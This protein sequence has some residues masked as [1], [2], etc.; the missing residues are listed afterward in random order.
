M[1]SVKVAS[2][3][4]Y[5]FEKIDERGINTHLWNSR[6]TYTRWFKSPMIPGVRRPFRDYDVDYWTPSLL[7]LDNASQGIYRTCHRIA[8]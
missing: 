1:N 7:A 3:K 4:W 8:R 5:A 2:S 6:K